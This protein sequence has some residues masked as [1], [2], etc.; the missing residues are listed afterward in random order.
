MQVN[1]KSLFFILGIIVVLLFVFGCTT[2]PK[3]SISGKITIYPNSSSSMSGKITIYADGPQSA[4]ST[5]QSSVSIKTVPDKKSEVHPVPEF[6]PDEIIVKYKPGVDSLNTA[7]ST[8]GSGYIT[9]AGSAF[10]SV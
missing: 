9:A 8:S 1:N 4:K 10:S 2:E 3:S 6:V 7:E 5:S